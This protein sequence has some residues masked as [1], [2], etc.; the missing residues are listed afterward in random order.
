MMEFSAFVFAAG[1][2][3]GIQMDHAN[4]TILAHRTLDRIADGMITTN[5]N[6][7]HTD[8]NDFGKV[9]LDILMAA[10]QRKTAAK[11]Y[12]PNIG[13]LALGTGH[14]AQHMFIRANAF[15]ITHRTR[16]KPR[17]CPVGH[18]QIHRHPDKRNIKTGKIILGRVR[19][20]GCIKKRRHTGKRPFAFATGGKLGFGHFLEV[21]VEHIAAFGISVFFAQ[22]CE[23]FSV[24][25]GGLLDPCRTLL[26]LGMRAY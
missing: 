17:P 6:R 12:I 21:R 5:G 10:F 4:R 8:I 20:K 11:R 18:P 22:F 9:I 2:A 3:M 1:I 13:N 24:D 26:F 23:F 19:R 15:D 16:A 14:H 25:H 7:D